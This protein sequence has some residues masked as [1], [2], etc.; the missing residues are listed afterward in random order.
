MAIEDWEDPVEQPRIHT[1]AGFRPGRGFSP[2][3]IDEG[4]PALESIDFDSE[5]DASQ[6]PEPFGDLVAELLKG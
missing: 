3:S 2:P 5:E 4:R 1:L 6:S